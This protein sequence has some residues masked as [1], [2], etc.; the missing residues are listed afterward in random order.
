MEI[1]SAKDEDSKEILRLYYK[2][3][4]ERKKVNSFNKI[5][6]KSE[7][8]VAKEG[9]IITGFLITSFISYISTNVGYV[10]ELFVEEKFRKIGIGKALVEK[11]MNWQKSNNSEVVFVTTDDSQEFYQKIGFKNLKN[12]TWLCKVP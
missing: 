2:L 6:L 11:A 10:D 8:F 7:I 1:I 9:S 4:P 5:E 3:Y 12:N